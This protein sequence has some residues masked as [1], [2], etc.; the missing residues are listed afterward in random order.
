MKQE[1]DFSKAERGKFYRK[2]IKLN[3]PV[4]LDE[5]TFPFIS[6]LAQEKNSDISAIVNALLKGDIHLAQILK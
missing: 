1:Y 3:I 2:E 5:T 4:Y 6:R